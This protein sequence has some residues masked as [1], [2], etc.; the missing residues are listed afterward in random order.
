MIS[1]PADALH[2]LLVLEPLLQRDEVDGLLL[3]VHLDQR[4]KKR[5]V[6]Q[7]VKDH[8]SRLELLDALAH[9]IVGRKQDAPQHPLFRF[10]GM[11]RQAVNFRHPRRGGAFP[12]RLLQIGRR[13]P[14]SGLTESIMVALAD[15]FFLLLASRSYHLLCPCSSQKRFLT[16]RKLYFTMHRNALNPSCQPIF[17]PSA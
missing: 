10:D 7:I 2:L 11:R 13:C 17:F 8:V 12:A 14:V 3:V 4:L 1:Q 6:A 9:A 15:C 16:A 5:L